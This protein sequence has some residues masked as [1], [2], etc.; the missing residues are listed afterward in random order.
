LVALATSGG[1]RRELAVTSANLDLW[2]PIA[3]AAGWVYWHDGGVLYRCPH[4]GGEPERL[5]GAPG[6]AGLMAVETTGAV[7]F[8]LHPRGN[9]PVRLVRIAPPEP[10]ASLATLP[11][12]TIAGLVADATHVYWV[13]RGGVYRLPRRREVRPERLARAGQAAHSLCADESFL[14]WIEG[15]Y[16]QGQ[17]RR[18]A[19]RGGAPMTL[20]G[21]QRQP[22]G[23]AVV[24]RS[25]YFTCTHAGTV[26][27]VP[28]C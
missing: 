6:H 23:L 21:G 27:R 18:V 24:E 9:Q 26:S 4:T 10:D 1:A 2:Q 19:K 17:V 20:A 3:A 14:Y 12:T 11:G 5:G 7:L 15:D 16:H 28:P 13:E 22:W 8:A 25:V